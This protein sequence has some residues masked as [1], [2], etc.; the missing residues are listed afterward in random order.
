MLIGYLTLEK[1]QCIKISFLTVFQVRDILVLIR[2]RIR[3]LGCVPLTN[4]CGSVPKSSV[5]FRMQQKNQCKFKSFKI[6]KICLMIKIKFYYFSLH[7][8]F[9]GK[10]KDLD[11]Q[12]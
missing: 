1:E 4:G 9:M 7:N 3:I 11:P 12:L 2:M 10:G 6:V 5:T 8:T